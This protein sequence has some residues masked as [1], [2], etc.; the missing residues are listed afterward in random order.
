MK[1]LRSTFYILIALVI[2]AVAAAVSLMMFVNPNRF[3][4][5]IIAAVQKQTG[6]QAVI[7]GNISWSFYPRIGAE[8]EHMTLTAPLEKHAFADLHGMT[9]GMDLMQ[10]LRGEKK[11][12]GNVHIKQMTLMKVQASDAAVD[13]QWENNVLML[14]SISASLYSGRLEGSANGRNFTNQP[15]WEWDVQMSQIQLQALLQDINGANSKLIISGVGQVKLQGQT[16]GKEKQ[17]MLK[18]LQGKVNYSLTNGSVSGIDLN[19]F[20]Q[21]A[22]E[23]VNS[24]PVNLA[25]NTNKTSFESLTGTS[26]IKNGIASTHDTIL[27]SANF[28]TKASGS[29]DLVHSNIDYALDIVP[30]H[31][32]KIKFT[33]PV[34]VA[35]DL[36]DPSIKLDTLKLNTLLANEQMQ[37][38]KEKVQEKIKQLPKQ[39]DNFLQKVMG[40]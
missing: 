19:F 39:V 28:T 11:L 1:F 37:K 23:I 8:V 26:V 4:P 15:K 32:E 21:S 2:L 13:I 40:H 31:V 36:S 7:D 30:Q 25:N 10:L 17:E 12:Q 38:V 16:T 14:S 3:K 33:I 27:V 6:Y 20:V 9:L 34:L 5:E 18:N 35:G 24:K 22:D 29:I